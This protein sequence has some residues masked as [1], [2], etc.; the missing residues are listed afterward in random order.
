LT[1]GKTIFIG[2]H[3]D[4]LCEAREDKNKWFHWW[5]K[6]STSK[7]GVDEINGPYADSCDS[8]SFHNL[9]SEEDD[10]EG[11]PRRVNRRYPSGSPSG[12]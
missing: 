7:N 4:V 12:T 2:K 6:A 5:K 10:D 9:D 11:S 1:A 3:D 8:E